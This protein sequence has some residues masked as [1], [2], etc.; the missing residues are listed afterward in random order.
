MRPCASESALNASSRSSWRARADHEH[1][2]AARRDQRADHDEP[3][4][5]RRRAAPDQDEQAQDER[6]GAD[7][8]EHPAGRARRQARGVHVAQRLGGPDALLLQ[9]G[10]LRLELEVQLGLA[11]EQPPG[12]GR[13]VAEA[14]LQELD[15][16][17]LVALRCQ[18]L[19]QLER[20][21]AEQRVLHLE[22]AHLRGLADAAVG[23][24]GGERIERAELLALARDG[25]ALLRQLV[26]APRLEPL[27]A[28]QRLLV[29]R[30]RLAQLG[31]GVRGQL[32]GALELGGLLLELRHLGERLL[33]VLELAAH[34]LRQPRAALV[35][36]LA[37]LVLERALLLRQALQVVER[38]LGHDQRGVQLTDLGLDLVT[39][40]REPLDGVVHGAGEVELRRVVAAERLVE[41]AQR[42]RGV[43]VADVR[44]GG[45]LEP[46]LER[47]SALRLVVGRHHFGQLA[48]REQRALLELGAIEPEEH[49]P[50]RVLV[51]AFE[52]AGGH[53]GAAPVEHGHGA[54]VEVARD[55]VLPQRTL[56]VE[57]D[58]IG[59]P[60]PRA[61]ALERRQHAVRSAVAVEPV[62]RG[63]ECGEQRRLAALV[64]VDHDVHAIG[65]ER[66][67]ALQWAEAVHAQA[68]EPH[69]ATSSHCGTTSRTRNAS[70]P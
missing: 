52:E 36:E 31:F 33:V 10:G 45:V 66:P 47:R 64:V 18:R 7:R 69:S 51:A 42:L 5:E 37:Q 23:V 40:A 30:D 49:L 57:L 50:H 27:D 4:G 28:A 16:L 2:G 56:N 14:P 48:L 65:R 70:R 34:V 61:P 62:E 17:R 55:G 3:R 9:R 1:A 38:R 46:G 53:L 43:R 12:L 25:L 6:G 15:L 54:G 60:V 13:Q 59:A 26:A 29:A 22:I 21:V 68:H 35:L 20:L 39:L 32:G 58:A 19:A 63:G 24:L 11:F 44:V 41:H 67:L 8:E